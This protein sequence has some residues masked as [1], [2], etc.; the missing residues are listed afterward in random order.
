MPPA[1]PL[2]VYG[3]GVEFYEALTLSL[4]P[5]PIPNPNPHPY[6]KP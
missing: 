6:P 4:T 5:T 2:V 1:K 3:N